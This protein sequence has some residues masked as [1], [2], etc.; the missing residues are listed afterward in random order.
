[1]WIQLYIDTH[2]P[3]GHVKYIHLSEFTYLCVRIGDQK[4]KMSH[5]WPPPDTKI[6]VLWFIYDITYIHLFEYPLIK[7]GLRCNSNSGFVGQPYARTEN[8]LVVSHQWLFESCSCKIALLRWLCDH[9]IHG[10]S[11]YEYFVVRFT[12]LCQLVD[13]VSTSS[14]AFSQC[15]HS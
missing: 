3:I 10:Y 9:P 6:W 15:M 1:M 13:S 4:I 5:L 8:Y 2:A 14:E 11:T 7:T 12:P